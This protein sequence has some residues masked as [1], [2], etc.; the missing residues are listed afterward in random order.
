ME[1]LD[2]RSEAFADDMTSK[3]VKFNEQCPEPKLNEEEKQ[4]LQKF[5]DLYGDIKPPSQEEM[6]KGFKKVFCDYINRD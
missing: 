3:L 5:K 2:K 4:N 6:K 1:D